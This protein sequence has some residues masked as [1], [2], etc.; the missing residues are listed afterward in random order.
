MASAAALVL[1][2]A[3]ITAA[4]ATSTPQTHIAPS[5]SWPGAAWI[6]RTV[7]GRSAGYV[8]QSSPTTAVWGKK[9]IV[10]VGAENGFVY[11]M[12]AAT[13]NE[14]PGWPHHLAVTPGQSAAIES[15][16]TIAFLDGR[17][18]APSIIVGAASTWVHSSAAE[19]EAWRLSGA[20]RFVFHVGQ[21]TG[22][23]TGVISTPAVGDVLG[24]GQ[25]QIVFGSW[26][27]RIYVLDGAGNQLGFAYDNAD[28]IWSSPALYRLPGQRADDIF[29]GSDAS[30][31]PFGNHQR[32]VGGFIADYRFSSAALD[33]DT[34]KTGPGLVREW[35]HCLNQS[36]WSSPVVGLIGTSHQPVVIVGTSFFEQPFPS[37]TSKLFAFDA[38]S[39]AP[40]PGWPVSTAGPTL[41]SAAIGV[42]DSSG[43]PAVVATSWDCTGPRP[44]N[45]FTDLS[46]VYAWNGSGRLIWSASLPGPESFAS[47]VLVPL[48][49][50]S[51]QPSSTTAGV[52][53]DVLIGSPNGLYP[54]DGA[55]GAF[56]FGT[57]GSNQFAAINPGCRVY[58]SV[59]VIDVQSDNARA[60]WHAVE[61][62]GGPPTFRTP[63]TILSYRLPVQ[64]FASAAWPMFRG[65][66]EHSGVAF[67]SLAT[68]P[69]SIPGL[70]VVTTTSLAPVGAGGLG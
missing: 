63:G 26:D 34:L 27:H 35:F 56:L 13:G 67:S 62:C 38:A 65:S 61:A 50:S 15:S 2:L 40:V 64:D 17:R 28:T 45:C 12:D 37:D 66:P 44:S 54:L 52:L 68:V 5:V 31:R 24:N 8:T 33:P 3:A 29:L 18:H 21:A 59:A 16:P 20:E 70:P 11:V 42:I 47:P 6:A 23:A 32:C 36:I 4:S 69:A 51:A 10:A 25:E 22:T 39:G 41:G 19:V 30:G 60:G 53:N 7:T 48:Q 49:A 55:T 1:G 9:T 43:N 57:N 46:K 58:N 14:L